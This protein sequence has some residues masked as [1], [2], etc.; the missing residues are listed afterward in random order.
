MT[1]M[2]ELQ[3]KNEELKKELNKYKNQERLGYLDYIIERLVK[4]FNHPDCYVSSGG[5]VSHDNACD[6]DF[7]V[8]SAFY[9]GFEFEN[10]KFP[11]KKPLDMEDDEIYVLIID[12]FEKHGIK[13]NQIQLEHLTEEEQERIRIDNLDE[14]LE[15]AQEKIEELE[16]E[17]EDL[18][19][20]VRDYEEHGYTTSQI[21][22][23]LS[24]EDADELKQE[25]S[26]LEE[27]VE[28]LEYELK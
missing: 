12:N 8:I 19:D 17:I 5:E 6:S 11:Y 23:M 25:V 15:E 14:D 1:D 20:R 26:E 13:I 16:S 3:K 24:E 22:A 2:N 9:K 27:R 4:D 18:E 7:T 28:D 10:I 21:E